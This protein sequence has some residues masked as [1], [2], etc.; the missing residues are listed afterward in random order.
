MRFTL[1]E[2]LQIEDVGVLEFRCPETGLILWPLLRNQFFRVLI[3]RVY[4]KQQPLITYVHAKNHIRLLGILLS[5]FRYNYNYKYRNVDVMLFSTGAGHFLKNGLWFNRISDYFTD[6]HQNSINVEGIFGNFIPEPRHNK[7]AYYWLFWKLLI[8]AYG[9]IFV[10]KHHRLIALKLINYVSLRAEKL[11]G[12][13]LTN[14]EILLLVKILA[15]KI[16]RLK[17]MISIYKFFLARFSPKL[18]IVE[19]GCYGDCSVLNWVAHEMGIRVAEMQ[20]GMVSAG[21]DAYCFSEDIVKS[22]EYRNYLPDDFLGYGDWWIN[23]INAPIK[24]WAVG[25]PHYSVQKAESIK[26]DKIEQPNILLLSD[27]VEFDQYLYLAKQLKA[28]PVLYKYK[29]VIRPHP[30]EREKVINTYPEGVSDGIDFDFSGNVYESFI[31]THAVLG[32]VSTALF[33]A[34]GLVEKIFIW[35]TPKAKFS[36]PEHPFITFFDANDFQ[37]KFSINQD[38]WSSASTAEI[39]ADNWQENYRHYLEEVLY[40]K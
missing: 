13:S 2:L 17:L 15:P 11:I 27:G 29:I 8:S 36:Y 40:K 37:Q 30:L 4:Y 10:N 7:K 5:I 1:K 12:M 39:W 14:E 32:E 28:L 3:S 23:Q 26:V 6:L 20:H 16:A 38:R 24:K 33:E 21:H 35:D 18:L 22:E 25:N 34:V 19:E 31:S 9:R